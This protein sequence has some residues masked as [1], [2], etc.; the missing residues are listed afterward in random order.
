MKR[1]LSFLS[2]VLLSLS[3]WP[4]ADVSG[5][6][7]SVDRAIATFSG[8]TGK[9]IQDNAGAGTNSV[10]ISPY[11]DIYWPTGFGFLYLHSMT[12]TQR[13]SRGPADGVLIY[14][15]TLGLPQYYGNGSWH[16][17]IDDG[18]VPA[19]MF[20]GGPYQNSGTNGSGQ[21]T[22]R[23]LQPNDVGGTDVMYV[24]QTGSGF[25]RV[26]NHSEQA[27]ASAVFENDITL[28]DNTTN[29]VST[30][31]HGFML[32]GDN[33][34]THFLNGK[35]AWAVPP[36]SGG[37][38]ANTN[39]VQTFTT[40][41]NFQALTY[42]AS[43][44]NVGAL[45]TIANHGT[46]TISS[47]TNVYRATGSGADAGINLYASPASGSS[48]EIFWF[49]S[50]GGTQILTN[51]V[52][53]TATTM[54]MPWGTGQTITN[55]TGAS[56]HYFLY[57]SNNVWERV[58]TIGDAWAGTNSG[59][60][61]NSSSI[62]GVTP[63]QLNLTNNTEVTV[64][65]S[66]TNGT[67]ALTAGYHGT[68]GNFYGPLVETISGT[69]STNLSWAVGQNMIQGIT[70]NAS[71]TNKFTG[72]NAT[73]GSVVQY[74]VNN[75]SSTNILVI[76]D[77]FGG[78]GLTNYYYNYGVSN[79]PSVQVAGGTRQTFVWFYDGGRY[80]L[81]TFGR[82]LATNALSVSWSADYNTTVPRD[83]LYNYFSGF[84]TNLNG[85]VDILDTRIGITNA[86]AYGTDL[87]GI[88]TNS[89]V[90]L[91]PKVNALVT[92]TN[93]VLDLSLSHEFDVLL[94]NASP[95]LLS[96]TNSP[97]TNNLAVYM[98]HFFQDSSGSRILDATNL[99]SIPGHGTFGVYTN[100]GGWTVLT[101]TPN[102]R[103][104]GYFGG[105]I[106]TNL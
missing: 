103:T 74:V 60:S 24:P 25:V 92:G 6:S 77:A 63:S 38:N 45:G 33:D 35:L 52:N 15:S 62:N 54:N 36:G 43:R 11:G 98:V 79:V 48:V 13:D 17:W 8:T 16:T 76:F 72:T 4:A 44:P 94:T 31:A 7:S 101:L 95:A 49:N 65:L 19:N 70:T 64:N 47:L 32:K 40:N 71:F 28:A 67:F 84:D 89:G 86:Q 59:T 87:R 2:V 99:L 37:G 100:A 51:Y 39:A 102:P 91:T 82:S 22:F 30:N 68:N 56:A 90:I 96:F 57:E 10:T 88:T 85:R 1:L 105:I 75:T 5:P 61:G 27:A 41:Q 66:N 73:A 106:T 97:G 34:S 26:I 55:L 42:S 80:L 69:D 81:T 46:A 78:A 29:N 83:T 9:I 50:S 12:S 53:G 58:E 3:A 18:N 93:L 21:G 104:N 20:Y 23:Y 14:N